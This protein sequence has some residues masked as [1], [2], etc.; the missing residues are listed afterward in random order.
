[1]AESENDAVDLAERLSFELYL[2]IQDDMDAL[3]RCII[4]AGKL[5]DFKPSATVQPCACQ[6]RDGAAGPAGVSPGRTPE[7]LMPLSQNVPER[8]Q[9]RSVTGLPGVPGVLRRSA[10]GKGLRNSGCFGR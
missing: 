5:A 3:R 6:K 7:S 4:R 8:P 2:H 10:D 1:M 9:R